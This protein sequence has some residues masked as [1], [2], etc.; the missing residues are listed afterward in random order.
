MWY[1]SCPIHRLEAGAL[2]VPVANSPKRAVDSSLP[3]RISAIR[4][5]I[6]GVSDPWD[7]RFSHRLSR[8]EWAEA[9]VAYEA[10]QEQLLWHVFEAILIDH[11]WRRSDFEVQDLPGNS[12]SVLSAIQAHLGG[13]SRV[14]EPAKDAF[15]K[16]W[17]TRN[18]IIH[19]SIEVDS[20]VVTDLMG[21]GH[22]AIDERLKDPKVAAR[23]PLTSWLH[24]PNADFPLGPKIEEAARRILSSTRILDTREVNDMTG[25]PHLLRLKFH[26]G[27]AAGEVRR[28]SC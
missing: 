9:V 12:S 25:R 13:S 1:R 7:A 17:R 14:W 22:L 21:V 23:H 11:N 15:A 10:S 24:V 6:F 3:L 16:I 19:R 4:S 18:D 27:I 5:Q 26:I 28:I 2:A 8:G 20:K